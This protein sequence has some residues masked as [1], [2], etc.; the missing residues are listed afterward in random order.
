MKQLKNVLS[1]V[2]I[3]MVASRAFGASS[4]EASYSVIER[5]KQWPENLGHHRARV[6]VDAAA[7]AV[8]IHL[9]W[10]LQFGG[11]EKRAIIVTDPAGREVAN[12]LRITC[13]R[14]AADVVFEGALPG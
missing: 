11:M 9:P 13:S 2:A 10:R 8:R 14:E 5:G 4:A 3:L 1:V 6:R 12:A 7:P